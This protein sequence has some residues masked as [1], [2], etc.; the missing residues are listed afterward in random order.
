M[1]RLLRGEG[2]WIAA[3]AA[4]SLIFFAVAVLAMRQNPLALCGLIWS[5]VLT[6]PYGLGQMLYRATTLVFTGLGCALAFRCGLFNIGAEGQLY[7]GAF[8]MTWLGLKLAFLPGFVAV[9]ICLLAAA[10]GG[11]A[12]ALLPAVLKAKRGA[13]EVITTMMMNFVALAVTNYL[14][15]AYLHVPETVHTPELATHVALPFAGLFSRL[16]Q[17]SSAN[18]SALLAVALAFGIRYFLWSTPRGFELR[19]VG[20]NVHAAR[21]NGIPVER[22]FLEI[23]LLSGAVSGLAGINFILG[24]KHYFEAGF[25]SAAGFLGI[26]VALVAKNHP[27]GVVFSALLFAFLS[28]AGLTLNSSVPKELFEILQGALILIVVICQS[29]FGAND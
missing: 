26:A 25:A 11:A 16:T 28:Q 15:S 3:S 9:P 5:K 1:N 19:A 20:A 2:R 17:S 21:T 7:I 24:Y 29:R 4:T 10:A 22:R 8:V 13:H 12:W 18:A 27:V 14:I 23:L 6:S